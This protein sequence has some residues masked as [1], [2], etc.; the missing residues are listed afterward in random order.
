M[1]SLNIGDFKYLQ[2]LVIHDTVSL[3][4][5]VQEEVSL[6]VHQ[7][8]LIWDNGIHL[9]QWSEVIRTEN[10]TSMELQKEQVLPAKEM[11]LR[12]VCLSEDWV[13]AVLVLILMV[14]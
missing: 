1:V 12:I 10:H 8:I 7:Q 6:Q 9:L 2:V 3:L 14:K 4:E 5:L 11:L 13:V